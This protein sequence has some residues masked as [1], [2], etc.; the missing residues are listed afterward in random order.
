[1]E[2]ILAIAQVYRSQPPQESHCIIFHMNT[3]TGMQSPV[4]K[5][6]KPTKRTIIF[7]NYKLTMLCTLAV[8]HYLHDFKIISTYL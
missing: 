8:L 2:N 3:C 4:E 6:G 5:V 7:Q 1:M